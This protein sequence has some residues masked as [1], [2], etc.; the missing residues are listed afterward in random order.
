MQFLDTAVVRTVFFTF[1]PVFL[2]EYDRYREIGFRYV[3]EVSFLS[4]KTVATFYI[5]R[6]VFLVWR[7]FD[8][9]CFK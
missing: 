2:T 9:R 4:N 3:P 1:Q 8:E 5:K 6:Q 7:Q